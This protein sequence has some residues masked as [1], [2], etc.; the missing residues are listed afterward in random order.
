MRGGVDGRSPVHF[1]KTAIPNGG[2]RMQVTTAAYKTLAGAYVFVTGR[3]AQVVVGT[4]NAAV[5][6]DE[7]VFDSEVTEGRLCEFGGKVGSGRRGISAA[8]AVK[9]RWSYWEFHPRSQTLVA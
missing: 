5:L 9:L 4:G 2:A 1:R 3:V 6:Y 7:R 8:P